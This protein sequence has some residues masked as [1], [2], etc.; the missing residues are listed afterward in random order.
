LEQERWFKE[1]TSH[2]DV[3]VL[4]EGENFE[5]EKWGIKVCYKADYLENFQSRFLSLF[6]GITGI[7]RDTSV[8]SP[9][10]V[11]AVSCGWSTLNPHHYK[12]N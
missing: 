7:M 11:P 8:S 2:L 1:A 3:V 10:K 5:N 6:P 9:R 4:K 12:S